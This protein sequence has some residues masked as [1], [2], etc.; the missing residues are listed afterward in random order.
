MTMLIPS[1][2]AGAAAFLDDVLHLILSVRVAS[3]GHIRC[4][5]LLLA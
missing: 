4:S 3:I 5:R 1:S 2:I